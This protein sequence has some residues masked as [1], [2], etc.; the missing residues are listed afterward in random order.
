MNPSLLGRN[1]GRNE[2]RN[3]GRNHLQN[4]KR[5]YNDLGFTK[6]EILKLSP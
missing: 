2:G 4:S 1:G 3:E 5:L 6:I